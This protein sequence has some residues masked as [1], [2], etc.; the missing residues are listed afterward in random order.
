MKRRCFLRRLASGGAC[1]ALGS[2]AGPLL[3]GD[4]FGQSVP[5]P[6]ETLP[7]GGAPS[8]SGSREAVLGI[9]ADLSGQYYYLGQSILAGSQRAVSILNG[10]GGLN[11][12]P[13][14]LTH[15]DC[16]S[17][18][19]AAAFHARA[20]LEREGVE[21]LMIGLPPPGREA[22][23]RQTTRFL[24]PSLYPFPLEAPICDRLWLASGGTALQLSQ[25][26]EHLV[27][28][29]H[30]SAS[31]EAAGDAGAPGD[32]GPG[33]Y[34]ATN[35]LWGRAVWEA[36]RTST[37]APPEAHVFL[38]EPDVDWRAVWTRYGTSSRWI[39][40]LADQHWQSLLHFLSLEPQAVRFSS[41]SSLEEAGLEEASLQL[42][43]L[44]HGLVRPA[45][46]S[47][48][49]FWTLDSLEAKSSEPDDGGLSEGTGSGGGYGIEPLAQLAARSVLYWHYLVSADAWRRRQRRALAPFHRALGL[50]AASSG[51]RAQEDQAGR[52]ARG[53]DG[54]LFYD[55]YTPLLPSTRYSL[56][57]F[58]PNPGRFV[59]LGTRLI[60]APPVRACG[61]SNGLYL[62]RTGS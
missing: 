50:V 26:Y 3:P 27:A 13:I 12:R 8:P 2:A 51:S 44:S 14:R 58:D 15:R 35:N 23:R 43:T 7:G 61:S 19:A 6:G 18:H 45:L 38:A 60:P 36:L 56:H 16:Q 25:A 59:R 53:G 57:R 40:N 29:R 11:G 42:L 10:V 48:V 20:L 31:A 39:V 46:D 41:E 52:L 49:P 37:T 21:S 22:A 4:T 28:P 47:P 33:L 54:S 9:L 30:G 55:R 34:I 17:F 5:G 24:V 1:F 62:H 32:A